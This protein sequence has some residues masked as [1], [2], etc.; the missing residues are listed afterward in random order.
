[1]RIEDADEYI[2]DGVYV[3]WD[4]QGVTLMTEREEGIHWMVLEPFMVQQL[5]EFIERKRAEVT[6]NDNTL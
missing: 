5:V 6:T 3:R 1:M 4:G 2:G